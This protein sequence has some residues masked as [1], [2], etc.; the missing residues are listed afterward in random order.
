MMESSNEPASPLADGKWERVWCGRHYELRKSVGEP[1]VPFFWDFEFVDRAENIALAYIRETA[2]SG[3]EVH[4]TAPNT[5]LYLMESIPQ[6][7]SEV[8]KLIRSY[9][10]SKRFE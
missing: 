3:Y 6:I 8:P 4:L 5:D 2:G 1:L 10:K 7:C 9:L